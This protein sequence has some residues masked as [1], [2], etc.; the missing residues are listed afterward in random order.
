MLQNSRPYE[1]YVFFAEWALELT[2]TLQI[3]SH[4]E[5]HKLV[6]QLS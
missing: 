4:F 3:L 6:R 5:T 2:E 1:K